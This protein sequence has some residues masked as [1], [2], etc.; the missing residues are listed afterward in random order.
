ML[1][2]INYIF[3]VFIFFGVIANAFAFYLMR[4]EEDLSLT[5]YV[6]MMLMQVL[7]FFSCFLDIATD[8]VF[9]RNLLSWA[10]IFISSLNVLWMGSEV[11]SLVYKISLFVLLFIF[12]LYL[13]KK[14][15]VIWT[16]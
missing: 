8:K 7:M 5:L 16:V 2:K 6:L 3:Q 4:G 11:D 14:I 10:V 13:L 9:R 15:M 12:G 1:N